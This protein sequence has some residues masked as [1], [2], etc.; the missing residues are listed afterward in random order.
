MLKEVK[1]NSK[2]MLSIFEGNVE[3][4]SLYVLFDQGSSIENLNE[5]GCVHL[6]E[7]TFLQDV[8]ILNNI[9]ARGYTD[10]DKM[11]LEFTN[12]ENDSFIMTMLFYIK[13]LLEGK[14]LNAKNIKQAQEVVIKEIQSKKNKTIFLQKIIRFLCEKKDKVLPIGCERCVEDLEYG[15]IINLASRFIST[16]KIYILLIV[17]NINEKII[18]QSKE[19]FY[20]VIIKK[21]EKNKNKLWLKHD[22]IL[23]LVNRFK[24]SSFQ[25]VFEIETFMN[26]EEGLILKDII[27]EIVKQKLNQKY[28]LNLDIRFLK[29]AGK[30]FFCILG[31]QNKLKLTK[32]EILKMITRFKKIVLNE[33]TN[34]FLITIENNIR[35]KY[36]NIHSVGMNKQLLLNTLID[37]YIYSDNYY[38]LFVCETIDLYLEK[39]TLNVI[40]EY[41]ILLSNNKYKL[42]LY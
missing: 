41:I 2:L 23:N 36:K 24:Y 26:G 42:I 25:I 12:Y 7:H 20:N 31:Y 21:S 32:N 40:E 9:F 37:K 33:V 1:I 11:I 17:N 30:D 27:S 19:M 6:L 28:N 10:F 3:Q 13:D 8:K 14:T 5:M 18:N 29:I 39:I 35:K 4:D 38:D 16:S 22:K 15:Q 34:D